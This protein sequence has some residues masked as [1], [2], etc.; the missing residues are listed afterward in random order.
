MTI[1]E[2]V[3]SLTYEQKIELLWVLFYDACEMLESIE[4]ITP[5]PTDP[6]VPIFPNMQ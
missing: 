1:E 5:Y 4:D 6:P 2:F 3:K